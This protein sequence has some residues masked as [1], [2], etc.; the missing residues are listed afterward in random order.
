MKFHQKFLSALFILT[1][2][3][4]C[5]NV[6]GMP[7]PNT[8]NN[9]S[10]IVT[11]EVSLLKNQIACI[12]PIEDF[13]F[14]TISS[15]ENNGIKDIEPNSPWLVESNMPFLLEDSPTFSYIYAVR[16]QESGQE[17]W[18][19]NFTSNR[20]D[21]TSS[22]YSVYNTTTKKWERV[23]RQISKNIYASNLFVAQD[24]S[25]W[26]TTEVK[27]ISET[28]MLFL[29]KFDE[30]TKT[31]EVI[32]GTEIIPWTRKDISNNLYYPY[33]SKVL[34]DNNIFWVIVHSDGIYSYQINDQKFQKHANLPNFEVIDADLALD[35]SIYFANR[36]KMENG[37]FDIKI[38][39]FT[40]S[41]NFLEEIQTFEIRSTQ[42]RLFSNILIDHQNRLWLSDLGWM[43]TNGNW[44]SLI[45]SPI[46][47]TN[48]I[49]VQGSSRWAT[50]NIL[51]E[52]S[53]GRYWF[54][55]ENGMAW[56]DLEQEKWCWFTT[57]QSNIVEDSEHNLWMIADNKLYKLPLGEQ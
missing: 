34:L 14:S 44:Y 35:G 29:S 56:L 47:L 33:Y 57:Y 28:E 17:V 40:P 46:F 43:E 36:T 42:N 48:Y 26:A 30:K 27:N 12:S 18:I 16:S 24:N 1:I 23:S 41:T 32:D 54:R 2:S 25:I 50:P 11:E 15:N 20:F 53:D 7:T 39:K 45:R 3:Y 52:S 49:L 10:S 31:F 37:Y 19:A 9:S 22:V 51:L 4:S 21:T 6:T 5:S 8:I 55:S 13:A 38:H